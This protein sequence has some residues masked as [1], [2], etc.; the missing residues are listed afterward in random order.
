ME[1]ERARKLW[2]VFEPVHAVVYFTPE[3]ADGF[4]AVGL[5][6]FWMGVVGPIRPYAAVSCRALPA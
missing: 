1:P 6:G 4:N 3:G 5:Q 2:R